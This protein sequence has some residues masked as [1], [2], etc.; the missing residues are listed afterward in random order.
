MLL[1][2]EKEAH[3]EQ[4]RS[5]GPNPARLVAWSKSIMILVPE[6]SKR[7][8][9]TLG[10]AQKVNGVEAISEASPMYLAV[11]DVR[12]KPAEKAHVAHV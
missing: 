4:S 7:A 12:A 8:D 5:L 11:S 2:K 6:L 10:G 3:R 1:E 9:V